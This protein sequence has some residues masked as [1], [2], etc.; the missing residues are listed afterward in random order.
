MKKLSVVLC[1]LLVIGVAFFSNEYQ[2]IEDGGNNQEVA[3][4]LNGYRW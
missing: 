2:T 3:R 1:G 4:R